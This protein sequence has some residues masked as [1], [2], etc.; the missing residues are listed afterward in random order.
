MIGLLATAARLAPELPPPDVGA[1]D[2]RQAAEDILS[3][4]EYQ[5]PPQNPLERALDWLGDR[6]GDFFERLFRGLSF[7]GAGGGGLG[8]LVAW[9]LLAVG[10]GLVA[11][12]VARVVFGWQRTPRRRRAEASVTTRRSTVPDWLAEAEDHEQA[13]RW[14]DA[15]RARY[16]LLVAELADRQLL[17]EVPGTTTGEERAELASTAP[18]VSPTFDDAATAF[19]LAW[20]GGS[21]VGPDEHRHF[22][23]LGDRVLADADRGGGR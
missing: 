21:A 1:D 2:A 14:R 8:S 22:R 9:L 16:R 15:L 17:H 20:Y 13:G 19:D 10:V 5:P 4:P 6:L 23:T 18:G 11:W 3:R 12:L 7:G